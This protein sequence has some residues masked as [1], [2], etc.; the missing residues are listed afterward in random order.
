MNAPYSLTWGSSVYAKLVAYNIYGDSVISGAGNGAVIYTLADAPLDLAEDIQT[1][2]PS[3]LTI[4]W[5]EGADN[6][7]N[8][9]ID[10]QVSYDKAIGVFEVL[11]SNILDK[12]L[13][14]T[15][16]TYG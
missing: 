12:S 10:Y 1:R 2:T 16:L 11:A 9:V 7:G 8:S 6:G 3:S 14:V 5:S 15:G 4:T 13:A